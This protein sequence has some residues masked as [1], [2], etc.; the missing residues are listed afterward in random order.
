MAVYKLQL[1]DFNTIEFELIGIHTS[2]EVS[3]LAFLLNQNLGIKFSFY[4]QIDKKIKNQ[5]GSFERYL[6]EDEDHEISWNLVE[7]KCII[8]E[9]S[10]NESLFNQFETVMYL[11]PEFKN[12]DF[13]LKIDKDEDLINFEQIL[14]E[15]SKI[16]TISMTYKID[17]NKIK[18]ISNLIF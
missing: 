12:I 7:N 1:D 14:L 15:I 16:K 17:K 13:I 9:T 2:I 11:I 6:F 5:K 3:K 8:K 10:T 18:T 4:D